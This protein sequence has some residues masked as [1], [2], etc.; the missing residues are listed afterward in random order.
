VEQQLDAVFKDLEIPAVKIGMVYSLEIV[1]LVVRFLS[2]KKPRCIVVD[3][4]LNSTT[5]TPLLMENAINTVKN[6]LFPIA[7]VITPNIPEASHFSG[8]P[9][10][11]LPSVKEAAAI[12]QSFGT[13]NI[14]IKGGHLDKL[15]VDVLY[16]GKKFYQFEAPRIVTNNGRGLGCTFAS[17]ITVCLAKGLTM[18]ESVDVSKKFISKALNHPFK[19]GEGKGPLNHNLPLT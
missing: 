8:L 6:K 12:L 5:G 15:P 9:I 17:A 7:T 13:P 3:P 19:I 2:E 14:L 11:D 16:T 4:V 10:T 18:E 1:E